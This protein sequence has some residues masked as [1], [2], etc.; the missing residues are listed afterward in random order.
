MMLSLWRRL[1]WSW[2][3]AESAGICRARC[4]F[5]RLRHATFGE[6]LL[7]F[8]SNAQFPIFRTGLGVRP[9]TGPHIPWHLNRLWLD[10]ASMSGFFAQSQRD[11]CR[12][13]QT[14]DVLRIKPAAPGF[15]QEPLS[16]P[17]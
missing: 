10:S 4:W 14:E 13:N 8:L 7:Y 3:R 16:W 11:L 1:R 17:C 15:I 5:C 2:R 9:P 12:P 6:L